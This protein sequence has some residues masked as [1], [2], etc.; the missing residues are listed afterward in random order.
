MELVVV[1][2]VVVDLVVVGRACL[3]GAD[4]VVGAAVLIDLFLRDPV[5]ALVGDLVAAEDDEADDG[6]AYLLGYSGVVAIEVG[7]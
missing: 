3:F 1:L 4:G 6:L 5:P 2:A 7:R